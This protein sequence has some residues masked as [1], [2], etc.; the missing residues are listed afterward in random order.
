MIKAILVDD[1]SDA[2]KNLTWEIERFCKDVKIL[3]SFTDPVEAISAINYLKPDVVFLD[4]EMPSL[5]GF[6]LL[7]SLHF[8]NFELIITSA[9]DRYALKAFREHAVDYLLKPVDSDDLKDAIAR[10]REKKENSGLGNMIQEIVQGW[11]GSEDKKLALSMAGKTLYIDRTEIIYCKS[12]GNYSEIFFENGVKEIFTIRL[13]DLE[14]QLGSS[15]FRVHNSY[16]VRLDA[17]KAFINQDGPSLSLSDGTQVPVSRS[18]KS[19]L[20]QILNQ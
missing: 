19:E 8:K 14:E 7:N 4:V 9:Y 17:I 3:D 1:E 18:R 16:I 15:F 6:E 13:K 2:L 12:D 10:V 20:L 11:K 5:D